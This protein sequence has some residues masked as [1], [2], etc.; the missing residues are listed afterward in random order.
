[1]QSI[2]SYNNNDNTNN[3]KL[4]KQSVSRKTNLWIYK[5]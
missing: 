5:K 1:M 2:T 4:E 3:K